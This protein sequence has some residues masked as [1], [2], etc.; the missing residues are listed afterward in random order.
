MVSNPRASKRKGV[1]CSAVERTM[2]CTVQYTTRWLMMSCSLTAGP[3]AAGCE[4]WCAVWCALSV[5]Y[6]SSP[7]L[8]SR[9][10][11]PAAVDNQRHLWSS[12]CREALVLLTNTALRKSKWMPAS[13]DDSLCIPRKNVSKG[14][15]HIVYSNSMGPNNWI[16]EFE[17][18]KRYG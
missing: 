3:G 10:F 11:V 18:P 2:W 8:P 9:S 14:L 7:P 13:I 17:A 4:V 15:L 12:C 6:F 5:L 1:V 16:I